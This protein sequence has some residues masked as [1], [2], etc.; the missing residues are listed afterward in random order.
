MAEGYRS[1]IEVETSPYMNRRE[2]WV[3]GRRKTDKVRQR[4]TERDRERQR[5][6]GRDEQRQ[7]DRDRR[8]VTMNKETDEN[9]KN[10]YWL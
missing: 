3:E 9:K 4:E 2:G 8:I 1:C 10:I 5:K 7:T 6:T